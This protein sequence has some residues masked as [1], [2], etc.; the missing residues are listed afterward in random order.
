MKVPTVLDSIG[1]TPL[2]QLQRLVEPGMARVLVK[3]E[4]FNPSGSLKDRIVKQIIEDAEA[5]GSLQ[6]HHVII[7]A[8]SGNT[9]IALGMI[10]RLKGYATRI[11]MPETKSV[12]RRK[13]MKVWGTEVVLTSGAD[14]N[15]HIWAAEEAAKDT[16]TFFY[17][18]QNGS[19]G[20]WRAHY[21]GT[22][23]EIIEQTGGGVSCFVAGI[24]TGGMVMGVARRFREQGLDAEVIGVEPDDPHSK[25]EGLLHFDGSYEPPIFDPS[26]LAGRVKVTDA[27]AM[28]TARRLASEEGIFAGPSSGATVF[29]ALRRARELGP[30][31]TVVAAVCDRGERYLSTPLYAAT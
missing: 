3:M 11:Y 18:N 31:H 30:G 26:V 2:V 12:E 9:G 14:Q 23:A 27:D 8:S 22:G 24:G 7:D 10:A 6:R 20:N 13:I 19:A 5:D 17:L 29:V 16:A 15:S 4:S 1:N 25:I 21:A 28:A